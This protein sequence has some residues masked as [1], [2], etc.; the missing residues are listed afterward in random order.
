[1]VLFYTGARL[2]TGSHMSIFI[3]MAPFYVAI[4][5]HYLLPNDQLHLVKAL[6][7][8]MAFLGVVALFSNDVLVQKA[9]Y[10]RGDVL[11]LLGAGM[12]AANTV[13]VKRTLSYTMSP[14]RVLY[15]QILVSTPVL[16]VIALLTEKDWFFNVTA[17]TIGALLFQAM[18]VV[19]FTYMM[20]LVLLKRFSATA[21]QSF[22]FLTP[23]WGVFFGIVLLGDEA[24][25]L[26]LAGIA[27]VGLGLYL[28]NR[29]RASTARGV[30]S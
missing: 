3:N 7:L 21:L 14:F 6:G 29:P 10:W 2:T 27:L 25:A 16:L 13:Y 12:W 24:Q 17:Y 5:A 28:I 4:G 26:M 23:V 18:V 30:A 20:W 8:L 1:F 19:V 22:T 11:V 15:I 9:G